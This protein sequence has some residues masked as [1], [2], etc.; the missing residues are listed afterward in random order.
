[1]SSSSQPHKKKSPV[2]PESHKQNCGVS[3]CTD[4]IH[5]KKKL[6]EVGKEKQI[7]LDMREKISQ[8][9][10][11]DP[12]AIDKSAFILSEWINNKSKKR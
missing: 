12:K 1:M 5:K 3:G 7:A 6:Y 11:K 8:I 4:P 9:I 2:S 10:A